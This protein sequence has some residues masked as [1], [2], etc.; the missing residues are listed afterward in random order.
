MLAA[1][2]LGDITDLHLIVLMAL[3]GELLY[4]ICVVKFHVTN[5]DS[6]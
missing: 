6:R 1:H 2:L 4:V 5:P 3:V